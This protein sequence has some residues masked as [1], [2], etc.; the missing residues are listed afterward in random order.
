LGENAASF[1]EIDR[2]LMSA[3]FR[4]GP[5]ELVDLIG[6][7]VNYAVTQSVYEAYFQDPKYRPHPIQRRMVESGRL[8]RKSGRG[9]YDY[10]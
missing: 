9:F 10:H 8:G 5:F 6:C 1:E 7:D 4:M 2:L 3:G